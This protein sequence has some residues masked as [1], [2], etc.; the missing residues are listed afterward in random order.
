VRIGRDATGRPTQA[1]IAMFADKDRPG[2]PVFVLVNNEQ[3][4]PLS[5]D[6]GQAVDVTPVDE[7]GV[8]TGVASKELRWSAVTAQGTGELWAA[9]LRGLQGW[10]RLFVNTPSPQRLR[11]IA[12]LDP[13][14]ETLRLPW[15]TP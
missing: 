3:R 1:T 10:I 14:V 6:D 9:N 12:L 7:K 8:P 11:S 4:I 5:K 15:A 2:S 13:P